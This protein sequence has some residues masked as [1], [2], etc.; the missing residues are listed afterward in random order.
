MR[1]AV[2]LCLPIVALACTGKYV[3]PTTSEKVELTPQRLERGEYI[4][5]NLASC[6]SCHTTREGGDLL[7]PESTTQYLGGGNIMEDPSLPFRIGVPN[8][9]PDEETGI[10]RWTDDELIRGIRDGV[11]PDGKLMA[12]MMPIGSYQYMSDED[13][14]A[15]VAFLRTVPKVKQAVRPEPMQAPFPIGMVLSSGMMHHAPASGVPAPDPADKVK[16]GKYVMHLG[17]CE[18]CHS[19]GGMG[20]RGPEDARYMGGG[21][22]AFATTGI[23]KLYAPNLTPDPETGIGRYS[24]EHFKAMF[25]QGKRLDGKPMGPPM[26]LFMPHLTGM[27]DEDLDALLAYLRSLKPVKNKVPDRELTAEGKKLFEQ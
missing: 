7:K 8:I 15:V 4:V 19:M 10:G 23:G 12:P 24:D 2:L 21:E 14:R 11:R 22:M 5:N 13:V 18:S 9:T 3:R 6:G 26:S 20:P 17:H 1:R 16:R 27:N 25:T